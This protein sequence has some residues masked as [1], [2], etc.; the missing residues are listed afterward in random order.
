VVL[1][2]IYAAGDRDVLDCARRLAPNVARC[3]LEGA[4]SGARML[5]YALEYGC[6]RV[7]FW[8]PNFTAADI[9]RAHDNGIVCNLFF[10]DRPDTPVP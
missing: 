10:G 7:Q 6:T 8:N 4:D 1:T 2:D 9:A 3:C 5:D